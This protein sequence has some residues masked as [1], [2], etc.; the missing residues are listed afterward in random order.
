MRHILAWPL[1][2]TI[3]SSISSYGNVYWQQLPEH[4]RKQHGGD[5]NHMK[6]WDG[7]DQMGCTYEYK[8]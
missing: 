7:E 1:F 5:V 2:N 6:W 3:Y 4:K 8:I